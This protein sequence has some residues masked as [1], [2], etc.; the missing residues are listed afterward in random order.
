MT[1]NGFSICQ[2]GFLKKGGWP[3]WK[4]ERSAP[5]GKI[6]ARWK[7]QNLNTSKIII[8]WVISWSIW[9]GCWYW[10]EFYTQIKIPNNPFHSFGT[11]LIFYKFDSSVKI[12]IRTSK[13]MHLKP[14][15]SNRCNFNL[16]VDYVGE[17]FKEFIQI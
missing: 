7:Y 1:K 8:I 13:K 5:L 9:I 4:W 6:S 3:G 16:S 10:V 15:K 12:L 11:L 2:H 17:K 14:L